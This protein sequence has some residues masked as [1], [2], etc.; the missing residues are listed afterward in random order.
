[1]TVVRDSSL[2]KFSISSKLYDGVRIYKMKIF[3]SPAEEIKDN[4]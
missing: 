3:H 2:L 4:L 1:M